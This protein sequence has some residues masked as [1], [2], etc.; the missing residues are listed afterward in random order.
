[1]QCFDWMKTKRWHSTSGWLCWTQ[2]GRGSLTIL[3]LKA[4]NIKV[5]HSQEGKG[6]LL[7]IEGRKLRNGVRKTRMASGKLTST[8]KP[9]I[10]ARTKSAAFCKAPPSSVNSEVY[11]I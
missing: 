6:V 1:M 8:S 10:K 4:V 2:K 3:D 7:S 9:S 5:I 11:K